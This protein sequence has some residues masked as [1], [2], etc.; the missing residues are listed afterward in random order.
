MW[1]GLLTMKNN[2]NINKTIGTII[3]INI[4]QITSVI[5]ILIFKN[6]IKNQ[7]KQGQLINIDVFIYIVLGIII[8]NSFVTLRDFYL[9][10]KHSNKYE[11]IKNSLEQVEN[12][13][14]TLRAQRHDFMN[15]LQ[16]VY[17]LIEMDEY[18]EAKEYIDRVCND[19]QKVN[20]VLKTTN[21]AVNAL[22]QAKL[23]YAEKRGINME[24]N[25]RTPLKDLKMPSWEFC[26]ILGNIIDNAIFV[27]EKKDSNRFLQIDLCEDVKNHKFS[28]KNN[29]EKIPDLLI[30][31]IFE[32]GYSTKGDKG[33]GMGLH[34]VKELLSEY[35]G[36]IK[37][38]SD[39]KE[40]V[41]E[42][43]IPK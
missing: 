22:I 40:T 34:I 5:A 26:R 25:I 41:F 9:I 1:K 21:P 3:T 31:R 8:F 11:M 2:L 17:S 30:N 14:K 24:L 19:I 12:L 18:D 39:E 43:K 15:H 16:V 28:I 42:G 33:E 10:N 13:N 6:T 23:L 36:E 32:V 38:Q 29:G 37:V 20:K 27:L 7:I 35:G 4:I